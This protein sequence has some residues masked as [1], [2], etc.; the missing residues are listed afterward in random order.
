MNGWMKPSK[1]RYY[2]T[3]SSQALYYFSIPYVPYLTKV[4][5]IYYGSVPERNQLNRLVQSDEIKNNHLSLMPE[6]LVKK[7]IA[8]NK[9]DN[10]QL[11]VR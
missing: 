9:I 1:T 5:Y 2:F 11:L 7:V 8:L 4:T 6:Y 10:Q 3:V